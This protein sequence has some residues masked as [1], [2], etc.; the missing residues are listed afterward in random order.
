[1]SNLPPRGLR[2]L[3]SNALPHEIDVDATGRVRRRR[4]KELTSPFDGGSLVAALAP[5]CMHV[6]HEIGVAVRIGGCVSTNTAAG[7]T[8]LA[9]EDLTFLRRQCPDIIDQRIE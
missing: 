5:P 2:S 3:D 8:D 7:P 1:M 4:R 6:H 9:N